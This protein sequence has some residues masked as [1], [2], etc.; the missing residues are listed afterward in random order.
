[1]IRLLLD[2]GADPAFR[3]LADPGGRP[4]GYVDCGTFDRCTIYGGEG[5]DGPIITETI[6]VAT[7]RL[8]APT[9]AAPALRPR[10]RRAGVTPDPAFPYD[11]ESPAREKRERGFEHEPAATYSPRPLRAKYHR[12]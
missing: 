4:F 6:E 2:H 8:P 1:M 9:I 5:P 12:R 3:Y 11:E 7:G 10:D